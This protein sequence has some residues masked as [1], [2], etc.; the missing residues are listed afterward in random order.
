MEQT[1]TPAQKALITK[2]LNKEK[3][4]AE[5]NG[6]SQAVVSSASATA[7]EAPK[8]PVNLKECEKSFSISR[9]EGGW[10]FT[11]SYINGDKLVM[12]DKVGPTMR[13]I[14]VDEF[15]IEVQRYIERME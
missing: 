10:Y 8:K 5:A 2:R 14:V 13:A 9:G 12:Q 7:P 6:N 3:L 15:K 1:L 4:E 11:T